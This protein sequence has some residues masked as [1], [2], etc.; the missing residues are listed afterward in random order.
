MRL[1]TPLEVQQVYELNSPSHGARRQISYPNVS[2]AIR[3]AK[4]EIG[5]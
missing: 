1:N 4:V 3:A 5:L 2:Q